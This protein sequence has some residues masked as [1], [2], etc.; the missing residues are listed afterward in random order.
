MSPD[1]RVARLEVTQ[2]VVQRIW[3]SGTEVGTPCLWA[4]VPYSDSH[5]EHI[6]MAYELFG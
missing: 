5:V 4:S 6:P 3:T 1:S 2:E